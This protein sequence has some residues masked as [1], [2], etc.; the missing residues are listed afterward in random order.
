[1]FEL[2]QNKTKQWFAVLPEDVK[3]AIKDEILADTEEQIN[4]VKE[5][6]QLDTK[7]WANHLSSNIS[8]L[9]D[10]GRVRR[11]RLLSHI[12]GKT[13]PYNINTY[14]SIVE[15]EDETDGGD[16]TVKILFLED[17]K[18]LN[19]AIAKRVANNTLDNVALEAL[20]S[21][22]FEIEPAASI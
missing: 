1:M 16:T 15:N 17:I 6:N 9:V 21:A 18:A 11:I 13:Y 19:E 8:V 7:N 20:K 12:A 3:T 14:K 4:F 22:A 5:L 2:T 10:M